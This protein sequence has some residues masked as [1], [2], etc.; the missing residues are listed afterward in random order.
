MFVLIFPGIDIQ[1]NGRGDA[2]Q[3]LKWTVRVFI[4]L[5]EKILMLESKLWHNFKGSRQYRLENETILQFFN[6]GI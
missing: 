1:P 5:E 2:R 6:C 4:F 3:T